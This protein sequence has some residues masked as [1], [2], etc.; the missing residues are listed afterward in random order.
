MENE[1]NAASF[2]SWTLSAQF[3]VL[4]ESQELTL[5]LLSSSLSA[6]IEIPSITA[7]MLTAP[8]RSIPGKGWMMDQKQVEPASSLLSEVL[9]LLAVEDF[10][11]Q[12]EEKLAV[13]KTKLHFA[14]EVELSSGLLHQQVHRHH[15][16]VRPR[17]HSFALQQRG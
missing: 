11:V 2:C 15:S 9:V 8:N 17:I 14:K 13:S 10:P 3:Q 16:R 1:S 7:P 12:K 4:T 5:I 6:S